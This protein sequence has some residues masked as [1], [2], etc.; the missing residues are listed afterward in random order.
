[1][2]ATSWTPV[3]SQADADALMKLFG[4]FHDGCIREVHISAQSFVDSGM[5]MSIASG[6]DTRVRLLIRRQ[7]KDPS[8]VEL[9]FAHI[10]TFHLRPSPENYDSIIYSATMICR[11]RTLYWADQA[12]WT[13]ESPERDDATWVA[14]KK[15]SWRDVSEWMGPDLRYGPGNAEI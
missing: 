6:V 5:S 13:P 7:W 12:G 3:T 14:A 8:A 10:D 2:V 15:L 1:M 4:G 9:L 11:D